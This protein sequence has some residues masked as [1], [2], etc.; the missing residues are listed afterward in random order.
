MNRSTV[1]MS[2]FWF[3]YMGGLGVIFPYMSLYFQ[4][5]VGLTGSELGFALA[6]HPLMGIIASPIWGQWADRSGKRRSALIILAFGSAA[7]YFLV[8]HAADFTILLFYLAFLAT[9]TAPAMPI[10]TSLSFT[11]L[12]QGGAGGFGKIR[13]WGT[14]GYLILIISFPP[15]LSFLESRHPTGSDTPGLEIIFLIAGTLSCVAALLLLFSG[16]TETT[17]TKPRRE[18]FALLL[19]QKSYLRLLLLAL[20]AFG[21]LS[22]PI[23]LFPI[24]ISENGGSIET[25]SRLWI[26]MLLLEIPLIYF[27]G[28]GLR[29]IGARGLIAL[30]IA[31][32]GL[33]WLITALAP[34]LFWVFGIQL[35]HGVVV[36]GLIIGMQLYVEQNV[37][38]RLR[39][40]GQTVLGT[41]MGLGAVISHLWAGAILEEFGSSAPY[42]IAG[43]ISIG[44]GVY[45]WFFLDSKQKK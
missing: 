10:A 42:L 8:P 39:A 23:V 17:S 31:C 6:M 33:R 24:F 43:P 7:G 20:F 32:D 41:V 18:D 15:F 5:N 26:P 2:F 27:A 28:S 12:G 1:V 40:T 13:V 11:I 29:K 35:L 21:F 3:F 37:P 45:A 4:Q 19:G 36:V 38:E 25:V 14:I 22:G 9:F 44:I 30:G 34:D 16:S